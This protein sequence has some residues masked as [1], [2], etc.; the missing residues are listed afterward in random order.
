[1]LST[2]DVLYLLA[3]ELASLRG[4]SFPFRLVSLGPIN[5]SFFRHEP[6]QVVDSTTPTPLLPTRHI[7][8]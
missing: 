4:R 3:N 6:L 1:M 2:T 8:R 5:N 7:G